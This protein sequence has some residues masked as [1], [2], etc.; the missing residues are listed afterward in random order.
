MDRPIVAAGVR[1]AIATK[2]DLPCLLLQRV[3]RIR[4]NDGLAQEYLALLFAG[5]AF[6]DY[7]AP[8]FTGI[9]VP[10]ISPRQ[11]RSFLVPLPTLSEQ[12]AI[13]KYVEGEKQTID[14]VIRG[15]ECSVRLMADLRTCLVTDV[16][17]GKLD[18][19]EAAS[20]LSDEIEAGDEEPNEAIELLDDAEVG[21]E[22]EEMAV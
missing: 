17:T 12:R 20:R 1:V 6:S 21:E 5:K 22:L 11:I 2:E 8:I 18:V 13:V 14:A 7:L 3:C 4:A 19:R 10:H 16:V 15:A 9:S